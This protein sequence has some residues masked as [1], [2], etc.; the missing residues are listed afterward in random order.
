MFESM[1]SKDSLM[2][3][4]KRRVIFAALAT[5]GCLGIAL[6][7]AQAAQNCSFNCNTADR[8]DEVLICQR[9]DLCQ[10]DI[11]MSALYFELRNSVSGSTRRRLISDQSEWLRHRIGCGR[12]YDCINAAYQ[13]R[14]RQLNRDY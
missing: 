3:L 8:P 14:I 6:P 7:S 12:D 11:R 4:S 10:L 2:K 1:F 9:G 13:Q 5:I